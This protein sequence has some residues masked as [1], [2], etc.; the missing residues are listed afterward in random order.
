MNDILI[1][2]TVVSQINRDIL[3]FSKPTPDRKPGTFDYI[4]VDFKKNKYV[5]I[6][7]GRL[8]AR[9]EIEMYAF[10]RIIEALN[11]A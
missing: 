5:S 1:G 11:K 6:A 7:I 2:T 9:K 10:P 4:G 8:L 3:I